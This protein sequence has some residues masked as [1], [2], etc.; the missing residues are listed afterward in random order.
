[1]SHARAKSSSPKDEAL[2]ALSFADLLEAEGYD[3]ILAADGEDV[4]MAAR[5]SGDA[6]GAL[7]TD[8]NMPRM[9]GDDLI[10]AVC[11]DRPRCR[12]WW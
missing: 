8:L 1:M 6:F 12:A 3:A 9:R 2:V 10:R 11:A 7:A 5:R 4:L